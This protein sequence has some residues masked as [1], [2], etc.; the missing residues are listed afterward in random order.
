MDGIQNP[1]S[2][3]FTLSIILN[4]S[5]KDAHHSTKDGSMFETHDNPSSI[6]R[7]R[8]LWLPEPARKDY[9]RSLS[10]KISRGYF[11]SESILAQIVDDLAPVFAD[12]SARD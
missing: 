9:L 12:S 11:T 4:E 7:G 8:F 3:I 5:S 10:D 2:S 1:S 6:R